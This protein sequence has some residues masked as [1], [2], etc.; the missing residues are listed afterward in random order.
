MER[1]DMERTVND[2]H[3]LLGNKFKNKVYYRKDPDNPKRYQ[4]VHFFFNVFANKLQ[5]QFSNFV[6]GI[7]PEGMEEINQRTLSQ[8]MRMQSSMSMFH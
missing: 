6:E 8:V 1:S 7:P 2:F 3:R 4:T 5:P